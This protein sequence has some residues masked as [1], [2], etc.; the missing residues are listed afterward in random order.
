MM[1]VHAFKK[2]ERTHITD[3]SIQHKI[4]EKKSQLNSKEGK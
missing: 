2:E 1:L 3:I 4:L